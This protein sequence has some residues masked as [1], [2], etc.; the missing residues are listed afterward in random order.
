M[1]VCC[2]GER[3]PYV[4]PYGASALNGAVMLELV[5]KPL[6]CLKNGVAET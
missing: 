1:A 4:M 5:V 6:M 2:V 3:A